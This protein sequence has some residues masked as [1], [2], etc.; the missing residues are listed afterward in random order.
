ML[1][2]LLFILASLFSQF[3]TLAAAVPNPVFS[4]D[5]LQTAENEPSSVTSFHPTLPPNCVSDLNDLKSQYNT[6]FDGD[7][8]SKFDDISA[9]C[10]NTNS[11]AHWEHSEGFNHLYLDKFDKFRKNCCQ[12][13]MQHWEGGIA[14]AEPWEDFKLPWK[15]LFFLASFCCLLVV[16]KAAWENGLQNFDSPI[17]VIYHSG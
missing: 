10:Y 3:S 1:Y 8:S 11:E 6:I 7:Y 2:S 16:F 15:Y 5:R 14:V 9:L 4:F 17:F 12:D 13:S